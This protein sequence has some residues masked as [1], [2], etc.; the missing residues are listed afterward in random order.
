MLSKLKLLASKVNL[1]RLLFYYFIFSLLTIL[2]ILPDLFFFFKNS[3]VNYAVSG[4]FIV[5]LLLLIPVLIFFRNL[6]VYYWILAFI[7]AFIPVML[8]SVLYMNIQVNAEMIG[9]VL[10]TNV[11]ETMELLGWRIFLLVGIM[12]LS[13]WVF[14]K[15]A[16]R[17]PKRLSFKEALVVSLIGIGGF[18]IIPLARTTDL[19]Y[20]TSILNNTYKTFYPFR[21]QSIFS[22]LR[23]ELKNMKQYEIVT[24]DFKFN[25]TDSDTTGDRKIFLMIIGETARGDH[26]RINGYERPTSPGMDTLSNLVT[27]RNTKS[28]GSMTIIS[29]P[30]LITRATPE[31]YSLHTKEK[32]IL[33]AFKEAGYYTAWISNQARYGLSG[34]IGMHFNDGDTAIYAGYGEN[35][36][37]FT[38]KHDEVILPILSNLINQHSEKNIFAIVHLI[39]SHWR[40]I[41]RY[42][43][44]FEKFT[45]TSGR[46]RMN[47]VNPTKEMIVN[48]YDNS[49]LYTDFILKSIADTLNKNTGQ[50]GFLFVSDHGE[51]LNENNDNTYFHSFKPNRYTVDVPLFVWLNNRYIH[52]HPEVFK[53]LQ[54]NKD[55]YNN[56]AVSVF[57][58]LTN[59]GRLS[60]SGFEDSSSLASPSFNSNRIAILGDEGKIYYFD[61]L[62]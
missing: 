19:R 42:P 23:S 14:I 53:N 3:V 31:D 45:P 10:D 33:S 21:L 48:E 52:A 34:N 35:E 40:Y 4:F 32:S 24:R 12:A 1:R 2:V 62:E 43:P 58:T 61:E 47:F 8:L 5:Q 38:G 50:S 59:V 54:K 36:T 44:S 39:G 18:M 9:L 6:R 29:V 55:E 22:L 11:S 28:G 27:F 57:H 17:L 13:V 16:Y 20:Y 56:S 7:V 37:N 49:I 26:W 41:L 60:L 15:L 30:L 46:N 51:N 25:A